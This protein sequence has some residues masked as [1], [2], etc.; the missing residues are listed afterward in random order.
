[1]II[2]QK[3]II[4]KLNINANINKAILFGALSLSMITTPLLA[5][6]ANKQFKIGAAVYGLKNEYAQLWAKAIQ[7]HPAVINK[8]I[9]L[10]VFDG[11]YDHMTQDSQF[12]TMITQ[13]FDAAIY[14]AI[15]SNA[16]AQVIKKA[17]EAG[18]PVVASNGPVNSD[19]VLSFVGSDDVVAGETAARAVLDA[20][21]GK[22][23]VVIIEGPVG[24]MGP[25]LRGRG[26]AQ[27]LAAY[28]DIKVLEQKT[29]N[30]SR[31]EALNLMQN[32]LTAHRGQINGVIA[33]ND[34]M[35]LGAISAL[36][37]M[38]IDLKNVPIAGIDG[39]SD[40]I[41]AVNR[42]EMI[43]TMR[44]DADAQAQGAMDVALGYLIGKSYI[45]QAAIW[46]KEMIWGDGTNKLYDVPW[47][48]ITKDNAEQFLKR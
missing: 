48:K 19:L 6:D 23:N 10:T 27:A 3:G 8:Q 32:W 18:L 38:Q 16:G 31:E 14:I 39:I 45:P 44:Q 17:T 20:M 21:G 15:D 46:E 24:Q 9:K 37:A 36:K 11:R 5:Q 1:M 22:G 34:E 47:T 7:L 33:Q 41:R 42:G 40:A 2:N 30:W 4:M 43:L 13:K 29:A 28:P 35:A 25:V 26:I 12:D